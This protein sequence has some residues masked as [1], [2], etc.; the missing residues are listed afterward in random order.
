MSFKQYAKVTPAVLLAGLQGFFTG[1]TSSHRL[2]DFPKLPTEHYS[3]KRINNEEV[4][5]KRKL[6]TPNS[7]G[8]TM[9]IVNKPDGTKEIYVDTCRYGIVS[10]GKVDEHRT[11]DK[12]GEGQFKSIVPET[13]NTFQSYLR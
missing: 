12:S 8:Y 4:I 6:P 7:Y 5:I 13:H 2:P 11:V 1:C 9:V 3:R 10:D